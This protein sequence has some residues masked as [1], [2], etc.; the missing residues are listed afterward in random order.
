MRPLYV[1]GTQRDVGK[2]T[3]CIGLIAALREQGLSIGYTKPLGQ[4]ILNVAGQDMHE[5]AVVVSRAMHLDMSTAS[6]AV[7][8]PPGRVEKEIYNLQTAKLVD[9]ISEVSRRLRA[10]YELVVVEG[11]GHVAMGSC[12]KLSAAH[13]AHIFE[14]KA[15]LISGGGIG[16]AID[17]IALCATFLTANNVELIG[18]VVNKIWPAKFTRVKK[19][20]SK[21]L[22]NLGIH[23]FGAVPY[24]DILAYPV[25]GQVVSL[26][27]GEVVGGTEALGVRIGRIL[28]AAMQPDNMVSYLGDRALV[29]TPGDRTDNVL[30]I[31]G[32]HALAKHTPPV[33]GVVLTGGFRPKEKVMDLLA[34][35][36][37]P[38]ILCQEDTYTV[39]AKLKETVFKI[40]PDDRERIQAAMCFVNE[41]VDIDGILKA[42]QE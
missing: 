33:A 28:V 8:L 35:S 20:T 4:R 38:T 9:R 14:A 37:L 23:S 34:N 10:E 3:F 40:A 1:V 21:G 12:L 19:A 7:P 11:M 16:R 29:I 22:A 24:E 18:V 41:Y 15:I 31:L 42:L 27:G 2:T 39:A 30:A 26:L 6:T 25:I 36:G 32:A 17:Q 13:V 5:D